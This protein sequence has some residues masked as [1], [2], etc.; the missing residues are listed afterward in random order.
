M[1]AATR[2]KTRSGAM[3]FRAETNSTPQTGTTTLSPGTMRASTTPRHMPRMICRMKG[4][5]LMARQ[6]VLNNSM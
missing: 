2:T 4:I 1:A 6:M 3:A 5:L